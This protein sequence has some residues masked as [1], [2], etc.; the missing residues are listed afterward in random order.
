MYSIIENFHIQIFNLISIISKNLKYQKFKIL[1][2]NSME[3]IQLKK[4]IKNKRIYNNKFRH[5]YQK[6]N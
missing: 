4:D 1:R 6:H 5:N 2:Y 3:P